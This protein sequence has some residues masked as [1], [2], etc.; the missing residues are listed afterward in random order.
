MARDGR[1]I[2]ALAAGGF[3]GTVLRA[4]LSEHWAHD[5]ASWPWATFV[6]NLAGAF[7]LGLVVA[8]LARRAE[9]SPRLRALL[10]TG[11]CGGLTTFS[12]LQLEVLRMLDHDA[13]GLAV[14]Y[15]AASVVAGLVAVSCGVRLARA[16]GG[17]GRDGDGGRDD[18]GRDHDARA[19]GGAS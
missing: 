7:V 3:A 6:V 4:S 1:L 18:A 13:V 16:R 5:P 19:T 14:G 9:P 17:G 15:L 12:T 2:A 10:G 8:G 11:F